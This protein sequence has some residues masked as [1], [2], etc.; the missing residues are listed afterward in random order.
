MRRDRSPASMEP[1]WRV[2]APA[3][4]DRRGTSGARLERSRRMLDARGPPRAGWRRFRRPPAFRRSDHFYCDT[5]PAVF[6]PAMRRAAP[7]VLAI[8]ITIYGGLVRL[9]AVV[10]RYGPVEHPGWARALTH[11]A[12]GWA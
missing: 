1:A 12:P 5:I 4:A 6:T 11:A 8:L 7:A 3:R 10:E 2:L 9:D